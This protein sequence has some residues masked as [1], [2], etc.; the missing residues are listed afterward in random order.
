MVDLAICVAFRVA[1][2]GVVWHRW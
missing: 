2:P 1:I